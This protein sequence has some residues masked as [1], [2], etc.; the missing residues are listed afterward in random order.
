MS[1]QVCTVKLA[2]LMNIYQEFCP[3]TAEYTFFSNPYGTL[4]L[5]DH[6]PRHR[7]RDELQR[8]SSLTTEIKLQS[9]GRP[10][11]YCGFASRPP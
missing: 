11:R 2:S 1:I 7:A 10:Q 4:F 6:I 9:T 5:I 8:A 3:S